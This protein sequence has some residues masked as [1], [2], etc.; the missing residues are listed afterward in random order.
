MRDSENLRMFLRMSDKTAAGT[1]SPNTKPLS[2]CR[3]NFAFPFE[4]IMSRIGE[5]NTVAVNDIST[6]NTLL[7]P[8]QH[9]PLQHPHQLSR[10][11]LGQ[12]HFH[13]NMRPRQSHKQLPFYAF[14]ELCKIHL[15]QDDSGSTLAFKAIDR[16]HQ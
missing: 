6:C 3:L 1:A 13:R 8:S 9:Y 2:I 16:I 12:H 10:R 7:Q 4:F 14:I 5:N 15:G 11:A